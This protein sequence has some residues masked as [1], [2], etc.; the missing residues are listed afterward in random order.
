M[1][2]NQ[3]PIFPWLQK[4]APASPAFDA[5]IVPG[6]RFGPFI[7]HSHLYRPQPFPGAPAY[8]YEALG[9]VEFP[10]AGPTTVNRDHLWPLPP[11]PLYAGH[12]LLTTGLGGLVAGQIISSPLITPQELQSEP[13]TLPPENW[14][15]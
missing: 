15:G 1:N 12:G 7:G 4:P 14:I 13:L 11:P 9:L 2:R 6:P 3:I 10:P 5:A 8:A